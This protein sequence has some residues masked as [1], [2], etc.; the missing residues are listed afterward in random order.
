VRLHAFGRA[1]SPQVVLQ[2]EPELSEADILSL[3]TLGV[4]S[5]DRSGVGGEAGAGLAAEAFLSASGLG[6]RVQR[7]LPRNQVF[8]D[9]SFHL[10]TTYNDASGLVEPTA[11]LESRFLTEQLKLGMS[12]PMSGRGTR[13][14]AE[15]RFDARTS[16]QVQ[17]DNQV[18]A[19]FNNVGNLGLELKLRWEV[20]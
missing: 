13:A 19:D 6:D 5:R 11:Q 15:Y 4:V 7:F 2:A 12:R 10:S 8:R 9:L 3:L 20:D 16:A 18:S 17:W 1:A 14:Q